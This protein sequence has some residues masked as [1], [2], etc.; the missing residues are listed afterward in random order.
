[1]K[2]NELQLG[3]FFQVTK[4]NIFIPKGTIVEVRGID[5]DDRLNGRDLVGCRPLAQGQSTCGIWLD[6]LEPIPITPEI[7][8]NNGFTPTVWGGRDSWC[9]VFLRCNKVPI[10]I[11]GRGGG[12]MHFGYM[13][14]D[15]E[16]PLH[17]V[18]ELQ[19]ALRLVDI[20]QEIKL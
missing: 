10:C 4:D 8:E 1:M 19:H 2:A 11:S 3:D 15:S 13:G 7:L 6:Y 9:K 20:E 12:I 14:Y 18:H 17:Y 5:A 16:I